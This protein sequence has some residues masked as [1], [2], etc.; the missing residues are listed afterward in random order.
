MGRR[1]FSA[2]ATMAH[3]TMAATESR[4]VPF[5]LVYFRFALFFPPMRSP[6]RSRPPPARG[7]SVNSL[8]LNQPNVNAKASTPE[9]RNSISNSRSAMG[10]LAD[11]LIHSRF[12]NPAAALVVNL[13]SVS[14]RAGLSI[15]EHAKAHGGSLAPPGP[16]EMKIG[17]Q[18]PWLVLASTSTRGREAASGSPEQPAVAV[19]IL[20]EANE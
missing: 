3:N 18:R 6:S 20:N 1:F 5:E 15:D 17:L 10:R 19:G 8:C 11:Q 4:D 13:N 12:G 16:D 9:S 7:G 2:E 14:R